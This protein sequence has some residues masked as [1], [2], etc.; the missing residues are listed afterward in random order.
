MSAHRFESK[1]HGALPYRLFTPDGAG[2]ETKLPLVIFMHGAGE[3][4]GDNKA[5]LR[6]GVAEFVAESHQR[7]R[8]CFVAA[9]QCRRGVWWNVNLLLD[10]TAVLRELPGVDLDRVYVT[11]LSMGGFATWH[12]VGRRPDLFAAAV[13]VCGGGEADTTAALTTLP[14]WAFHG[15]AD[16]TVPTEQSRTMIDAIRKAGGEPKYTEYPE[17]A[18]D[19]WTRTYADVAMH[20]WLFAQRRPAR[21]GDTPLR[22][23]DRVLFFGDSITEAG[24]HGKGYIK[25]I[26]AD[27]RERL[28]ESK[29]EL[30]GAGISGNRV[31]DLLRRLDSDVVAKRPTVVFIY[32]GIND[33]WHSQQGHGTSKRDYVTGLRDLVARLREAKVRVIM[34][35][36]SVIGEKAVGINPLDTMLDDYAAIS[37]RVALD[38]QV[39]MVDLRQQFLAFL[40]AHHEADAERGVLTTDGVH[41]N[42]AGNRLVADAVLDAFG[43]GAKDPVKK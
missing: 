24:G 23:G 37:R 21:V 38:T 28:P 41:L 29:V 9:P 1:E 16:H 11:G 36:P 43:L 14:I 42:D 32:I 31:P 6:H 19:S 33:V 5:Q 30:I 4:G 27:L 13:P 8:P 26:E 17:V 15:G 2:G 20:E 40:H 39:Q 3:R 25:L 10:F 22:D 18:H 35:T 12:L 34:S 7:Q